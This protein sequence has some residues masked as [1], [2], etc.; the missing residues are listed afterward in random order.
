MGEVLF[1]HVYRL[2]ECHSGAASRR[3]LRAHAAF[4]LGIFVAL[5]ILIFVSCGALAMNGL[6]RRFSTNWAR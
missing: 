6:P 3:P 2:N 4:I 1:G 5:V